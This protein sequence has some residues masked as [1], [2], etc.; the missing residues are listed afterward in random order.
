MALMLDFY[1]GN[2]QPPYKDLM[3]KYNFLLFWRKF[4]M[5]GG[6][7]TQ[8]EIDIPPMKNAG[9]FLG[10]TH[11]CDPIQ[12]W[13][14]QS[15]YFLNQINKWNPVGL[16]YDVEQWWNDWDHQDKDHKLAPQKIID[17]TAF[18]INYV[19]SRVG[20]PYLIYTARWFTMSYC[21]L[22]GPWIAD[23]PS[24]IA[25]YWDYGQFLDYKGRAVNYTM[26]SEAFA[27]TIEFLKTDPLAKPTGVINP[28]GRQFS[29]RIMLDVCRGV[30]FDMSNWY[31]TDE[32]FMTF[33]NLSPREQWDTIDNKKK[34][35]MLEDLLIEH[36]HLTSDGFVI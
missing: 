11:W 24:L 18:I 15:E 35:R 8:L 23:K 3:D 27:S 22:L 30:N 29:S 34:D 7:D 2:P 28:K 32:S 21:P 1:S 4:S 31:G 20:L 10:G 9:A 14:N 5:G 26:T 17:N 12:N 6:P 13:K 25:D 36:N 33:F 16:M 19:Q